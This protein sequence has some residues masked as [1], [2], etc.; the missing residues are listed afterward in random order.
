LHNFKPPATDDE[1]RASAL[2]FFRK[3]S[4]FT[5]P[6]KADQL[7]FERGWRPELVFMPDSVE[8]VGVARVGVR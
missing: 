3:L 8:K 1:I 7:A 6:S 4:G 5:R 2:Q